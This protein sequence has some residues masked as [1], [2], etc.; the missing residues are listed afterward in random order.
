[1]SI[2]CIAVLYGGVTAEREVSLLSGQ[3]VIDGLKALGKEV[4]AVDLGAN[5]AQQILELNVDLAFIALHGGAGEDGRVQAL[6]DLLNLS[7]T[8]SGVMASALALDKVRCKQLWKGIGLP[9]AEFAMLDNKTDWSAELESLGGHVMVK[10][11]REGSSVGMSQAQSTEE[12]ELAYRAATRYDDQ[13]MAEAWLSGDEYSVAI[14]G[15]EALPV[16]QLKVDEEF[17]TYNAKYFSDTTGY[18]C[19]APIN[20][21]QEEELRKLA[22]DAFTSIGCRGWG[23]V[24]L[25][26]DAAG[27]PQLL[28]VNTVPGMTSHSLVPMAAKQAGYEFP[29]LLERIVKEVRRG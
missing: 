16:I 25:M 1:M 29:Q 17:Y 2:Q 10:P 7:Y 20:A 11:V 28:E 12:L 27:A 9:T 6:L 13:V 18:L 24:D 8:G 26:L 14:L 4:I 5:M 3:A 23:R 19:P 22:L 15:E 21:A